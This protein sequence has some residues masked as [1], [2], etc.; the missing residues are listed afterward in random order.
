MTDK[1]TSKK[2][3]SDSA[4]K[5]KKQKE[6]ANRLNKQVAEHGGQEGPDPTRYSDWEKGGRCSDF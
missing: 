5:L 1:S 4:E 2:P 6:E 3:S